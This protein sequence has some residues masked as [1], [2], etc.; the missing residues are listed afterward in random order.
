MHQLATLSFLGFTHR[1]VKFLWLTEGLL[2]SIAGALLGLL[3]AIGYNQVVFNALN[4]IWSTIVRTQILETAI[5]LQTL[6]IGFSTSVLIS[7]VAIYISLDRL[8]KQSTHKL[9]T[10]TLTPAK[11]WVKTT[12][13][14]LL[15]FSSFF[16]VALV[17][18]SYQQTSFQNTSMFFIS[19]AL[20]L[21]SCLLFVRKTFQHRSKSRHLPILRIRTIILRNLTHN[22]HQS[23]L[24]IAVFAI[25]TFIVLSTGAHRKDLFYNAHEKSSGTGGFLYYAETTVPILNDLNDP[26]VRFLSGMTKDYDIVQIREHPG[27]DASCLNLNRTKTPGIMGIN[28][29]DLTGRFRFI[30]QMDDLEMANPWSSLQS[31]LGE[32]IIPAVADQSVIQW[33]LGMAVGDTLQ[34]LD[35]HGEMLSLKLIGGLANSIFQGNVLI[36]DDHFLR[37]FPS[38][39]GSNIMLV[40]GNPIDQTNIAGE[41]RNSLRNH[42]LNLQSAPERL[43]N[44]NSVENTYLSIFL[45]LGGMGLMI[46]TLG[47]AIVLTRNL[48]DRKKELGIMRATGFRDRLILNLITREHFYLLF[49]GVGIGLLS[50]MLATLPS[51]LNPNVDFSLWSILILFCF[52][53]GTGIFWILVLTTRFLKVD[54]IVSAL[55]S[56]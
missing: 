12:E 27:D 19:G 21:L 46:G 5:N 32:N 45:I 39:S 28:P 56:E 30:N 24:V 49:I 16:T 43:A 40:D 31:G 23:F 15:F 18:W 55:S 42:G 13:N 38:S 41:L 51:W 33:G 44:F 20:L 10:H 37:H 53:I 36:A 7:L 1:K 17:I 54:K 35:E 4:S 6:L 11:K 3:L 14:A 29:H 25:A 48:L 34:Y 2:V 52:I 26:E 8:L 9:Q 22:S 50:A 47:L